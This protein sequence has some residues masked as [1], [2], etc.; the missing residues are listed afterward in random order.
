MV[1]TLSRFCRRYGSHAA[2]GV[3]DGDRESAGSAIEREKEKC[4]TAAILVNNVIAL[5]ALGITT[6][7]CLQVKIT[8]FK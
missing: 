2:R 6:G 4:E 8:N 1:H 7:F 3:S 5:D